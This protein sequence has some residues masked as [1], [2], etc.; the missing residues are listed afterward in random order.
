MPFNM[1]FPEAVLFGSIAGF[2]CTATALV[3]KNNMAPTIKGSFVGSLILGT[4]WI[5]KNLH[6]RKEMECMI[7]DEKIRELFSRLED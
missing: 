1:S 3:V 2:A 7:H 6:N 4:V 5:A